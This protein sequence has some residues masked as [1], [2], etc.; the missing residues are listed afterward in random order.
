MANPLYGMTMGAPQMSSL[1]SFMMQ[2]Q[3]MNPIQ[4]TNAMYQAMQNP[5]QFIRQIAPDLPPEIASDSNR[6]LQYMQQTMGITNEQI[7]Q[8]MM[9]QM[10]RF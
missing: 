10:P 7:Q 9:S 8:A 1:Q 2:V 4:R 6:L 5:A 3:Q